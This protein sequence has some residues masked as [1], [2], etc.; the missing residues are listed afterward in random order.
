MQYTNRRNIN[1]GYMKL[2]VWNDAI[3]LFA[4]VGG[5]LHGV[6][7]IDIR[8]KGQV[9]DAAQ[10]VSSNI[11]EGYGRKS[12]KEYLYF[13]NVSLGSLAEL[14]TRMIGLKRM[15]A[16]PDASFEAFDLCHYRVENR[17]L[18]LIRSLQV[19]RKS[20]SWQSEF[21]D[22]TQSLPR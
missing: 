3:E 17:L 4:V 18:A 12:I 11:S 5:I 1:R 7:G 14:M 20:G 22:K 15:E 16:I 21:C 9:L 8:L 10:S 13:L 6:Q 2:D 19:K